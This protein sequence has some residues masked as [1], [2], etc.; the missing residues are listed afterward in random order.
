MGDI[1]VFDTLTSEIND[2]LVEDSVLKKTMAL[3]QNTEYTFVNGTINDQ[4]IAVTPDGDFVIYSSVDV[5]LTLENDRS[6]G[7]KIYIITRVA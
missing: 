7:T 3:Y 1:G 5:Q 6:L 4:K 2:D